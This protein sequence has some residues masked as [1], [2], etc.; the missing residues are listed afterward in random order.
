MTSAYS[1][2]ISLSD[3]GQV[4][5][6]REG[7]SPAFYCKQMPVVVTAKVIEELKAA[8]PGLESQV[9]RLCLHEN[10]AADFHSMIIAQAAGKYFLPHKHPGKGETWHIIDGEMMA[11]VFDDDGNVVDSCHLDPKTNF[12]YRVGISMYHTIVCLTDVVVYHE[13]KPGP[14]IAGSDTILAPWGPNEMD[15]DSVA[16]YFNKLVESVQS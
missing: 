2:Q 10:P 12:L 13:S 4:D 6:N 9:I 5:I 11:F 3:R 7:K 8:I 1:S 16:E 14:F 15:A